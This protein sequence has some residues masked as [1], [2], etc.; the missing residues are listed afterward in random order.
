[1]IDSAE[2]KNG[3]TTAVISYLTFIGLLIA[4]TMNAEPRNKFASFHVR[5]S[6][7]LNLLFLLLGTFVTG[8]N[9]WMVSTPFYVFFSILWFFAF[10][11]ALQG[12]LQLIPFLGEYFQKWFKKL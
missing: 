1:M 6:L 5:Q 4:M 11:S 3:K 2:I 7:G 10:I 12:K 9:T 8:F